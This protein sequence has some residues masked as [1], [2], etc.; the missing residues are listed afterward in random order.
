MVAREWEEEGIGTT[1][2]CRIFFWDDGN[3]PNYLMT[4]QNLN[5]WKTH[6]V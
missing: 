6:G 5:I 1:N 2:G 3:A 4:A